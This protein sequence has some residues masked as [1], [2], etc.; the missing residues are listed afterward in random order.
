[1]ALSVS[2]GAALPDSRSASNARLRSTP[3]LHCCCPLTCCSAGALCRRSVGHKTL[4][5]WCS[6]FSVARPR[7]KPA[8]RCMAIV[9]LRASRQLRLC[10]L[11]EVSHRVGIFGGRDKMGKRSQS[12]AKAKQG[13][14]DEKL[15][16]H[17]KTTVL[18]SKTKCD[19]VSQRRSRSWRSPFR[20]RYP[21]HHAISRVVIRR[22]AEGSVVPTGSK[23]H[24]TE[25][26][27]K[28]TINSHFDGG[29]I[30]V[31]ICAHE[32][33]ICQLQAKRPVHPRW[34]ITVPK[35]TARVYHNV[36]VCQRTV[37]TRSAPRHSVSMPVTPHMRAQHSQRQRFIPADGDRVSSL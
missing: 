6:S 10:V 13:P 3:L 26:A 23:S 30:E 25:A 4:T 11:S 21:P 31:R 19:R 15:K 22:W 17:S 35:T 32:R 2:V 9:A 16:Q 18:S 27:G 28:V 33:S 8:S 14:P 37:I 5:F 20:S 7:Y 29:N 24:E 36:L 1:V 12:A 34:A